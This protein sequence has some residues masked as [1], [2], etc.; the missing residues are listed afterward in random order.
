MGD[1]IIMANNAIGLISETFIYRQITGL[2]RLEPVALAT[3]YENRELF[4]LPERVTLRL[5]ASSATA[6][7]SGLVRLRR[8]LLDT[9]W[10]R[11]LIESARVA[12]RENPWAWPRRRIEAV[13]D[14]CR[15]LDVKLIV[16]YY[17]VTG[18]SI[19]PVAFDLGIPM[20]I[21][22]LGQDASRLL[23]NRKYVSLLKSI[24]PGVAAAVTPSDYLGQR[25]KDAG[26][27]GGVVRTVNFGV[28]VP[29][30]VDR[31]GGEGPP[32]FLHVGRLVEKKGV[33]YSLKAFAR[34][35]PEL[36]DA[37]F[38]IAGDGA[39]RGR[40]EALIEELGLSGRAK[41]L[42]PIPN[43]EV[44]A[45]MR[46]TDVFVQH[47]VIAK[48]GDTEGLPVS[49]LEAMAHGLPVISTRHAG[50]PEEV[51]PGETGFLVDERDVEAMAERMIE[52]GADAK[53]R[54]EMGKAGRARVLDRFET[55]KQ[56]REL[57]DLLI[58]IIGRK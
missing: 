35:L 26:L 57:E 47:S 13:K 46:E 53:L 48:S 50:I 55:G 7:G 36:G 18:V 15:E 29:E 49:I 45:L 34:A 38:I 8:R 12:V 30:A 54:R 17:G 11:D 16:A 6:F 3:S 23:R 25:L 20:V 52:L 9:A 2:S 56:V 1:K 14:V 28:P 41:T 43:P 5:H 19:A 51:A 37:R 21:H 42:G 31:S 39:L 32:R 58:E 44:L 22:F 27:P 40:I 10:T 24:W 4:P 33:E